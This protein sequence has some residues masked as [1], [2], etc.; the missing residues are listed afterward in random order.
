MKSLYWFLACILFVALPA[1]AEE[2]PPSI[3][4]QTS[5]GSFGGEFGG[6][7][8]F[9]PDIPLGLEG[10]IGMIGPGKNGYRL[11]L[12]T[13]GTS[14]NLFLDQSGKLCAASLGYS[15]S[16]TWC[17]HGIKASI[18]P[19]LSAGKDLTLGR[20]AGWYADICLEFMIGK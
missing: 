3:Y 14:V 4:L 9:F 11:C 6:G 1:L 5:W 19:C 20:N 17:Y 18:L 16:R 7:W 8:I 10:G 12:V 2:T 15:L 13:P